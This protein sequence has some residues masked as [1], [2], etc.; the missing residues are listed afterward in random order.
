MD[1]EA[2]VIRPE[3]GT[4][5]NDEPHVLP[6]GSL[7]ELAQVLERQWQE[8]KRLRAEGTL[9]PYVFHRNAKRIRGFRKAW[10]AAC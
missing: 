2:Q 9:C 4:T 10:Q 3:P 1:R 8:H 5:K 7:P 6:Y